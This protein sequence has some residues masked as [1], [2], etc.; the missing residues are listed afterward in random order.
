MLHPDFVLR[1]IFRS[2]TSRRKKVLV[3][4]AG[5]RKQPRD[6][7]STYTNMPGIKRKSAEEESTKINGSKKPKSTSENASKADKKFANKLATREKKP[8]V[9]EGK[10][11]KQ[12]KKVE[13]SDEEDTEEGGVA[14]DGYEEDEVK[15][16]KTAKGDAGK[17]PKTD[18]ALNGSTDGAN[19][20]PALYNLKCI[21]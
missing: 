17:L 8:K 14:L 2:I 3:R 18:S 4:I 10:A 12:K 15:P 11:E 1:S 5:L 16:V 9:K 7:G 21:H 19:G 20:M 6:L 13:E